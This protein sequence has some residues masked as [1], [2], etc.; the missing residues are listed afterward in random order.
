MSDR[1]F[2][3]IG[4][5]FFKRV[6]GLHQLPISGGT[7]GVRIGDADGANVLLR[8]IEAYINITPADSSQEENYV[9]GQ[10]DDQSLNIWRLTSNASGTNGGGI[11]LD[12]RNS[13]N[14]AWA[15]LID[16]DRLNDDLYI[17]TKQLD[18]VYISKFLRCLES[19]RITQDLR[20]ADTELT[21]AAGAV[22]ATGT[23][24][25]IDTQSDAATDNLDTINGGNDNQL[26]IISSA[27]NSRDV[28]VRDQSVSGGN[29]HLDAATAFTFTN[30]R[31][32]LTLIY[33]TRFN[34]WLEISRSNNQ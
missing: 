27:S 13:G 26:L 23:R 2:K 6:D 9:L 18:N 20:F 10:N 15:H 14:T 16:H 12:G 32:L 3:L 1:R 17:G 31:D 8:N 22:T 30:S 24:H 5:G 29:V 7:D 19:V 21:I 33:D 28:T 34:Q 25:H 4:Q 11:R